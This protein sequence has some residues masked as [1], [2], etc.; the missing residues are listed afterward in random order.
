MKKAVIAP[1]SFKGTMSSPEVCGII[2][3]AFEKIKPGTATVQIPAAD[4]GEGTTDAFLYAM[5][6][7]KVYVKTKNP[8][9]EDM[10]AYYAI[11]KDGTAVIETA[12]ASGLT[13]IENKKDPLNASTYGTGLLIK[14]ALDKNCRKIILGLGGSATSDGGAGIISALGAKLTNENGEKIVPSN[15]GLGSLKH[16]DVSALDNRLK[17]R[18][19][20]IACDV[21]NVLCGPLGAARVFG[22]QKGADEKTVGILD[23]NL[24][25]YAHVLQNKTGRD[26][27]GVPKTGAAG[28]ILA[29]L[30]S[31]DEF[32]KCEICSGIDIILDAAGFDEA[33][34]D[35]DLVIT[36]EGRFDSQSLYGKA[37]S[38]IAKRAKKQNK[39]VIVIAGAAEG[40]GDEIYDL[41]IRA[42]FCACSGLYADFEQLKKMCA[43]D[44]YRTAENILRVIH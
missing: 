14:D 44:L 5:G 9:F 22:P 24:K 41:G 17:E 12:A 21:G 20:V 25:R 38:G 23:E 26:I 7:E 10:E 8:L 18:E 43:G 37:V 27:S 42:V 34:R 28:G 16:I 3:R 36:G 32:F 6:G 31:F 39:P 2:A 4:G 30:L 35:A 13:L 33:I 11:L 19:F 29:S 15:L 40:Y 1:D